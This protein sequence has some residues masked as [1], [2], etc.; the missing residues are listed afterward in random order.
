MVAF[1]PGDFVLWIRDA[2]L[3]GGPALRF[4]VLSVDGDTVTIVTER[5]PIATYRVNADHLT[6]TKG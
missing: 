2:Q 3:H 5:G 4:R 1:L 6:P